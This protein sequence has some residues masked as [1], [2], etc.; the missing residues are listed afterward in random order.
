MK[1]SNSRE[2]HGMVRSVL[3][4]IKNGDEVESGLSKKEISARGVNTSEAG[5]CDLYRLQRM[6]EPGSMT[7]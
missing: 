4:I 6:T 5:V 1:G 3:M 2:K 7:Y